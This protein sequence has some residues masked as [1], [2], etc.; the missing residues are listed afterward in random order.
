MALSTVFHSINSP[1]NFPFSH[2][3]L[4]VLSLS[5][6]SFQLYV[7]LW[8]SPS[9]LGSK[10]QITKL[11]TLFLL[12][13]QLVASSSCSYCCY[14]RCCFCV[15]AICSVSFLL[16]RFSDAYCRCGYTI[17]PH[18]VCHSMIGTLIKQPEQGFFTV[19]LVWVWLVQ[20]RFTTHRVSRWYS[21]YF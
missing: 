17:P 5:H 19:F 13:L 21:P 20:T 3:V 18:Y 9:A 14:F 11:P 1:N 15:V 12:L 16:L 2:S 10:R 8:K 7:S 4:P 6:R